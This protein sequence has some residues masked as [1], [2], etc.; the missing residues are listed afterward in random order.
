VELKVQGEQ[1]K[2]HRANEMLN[3]LQVGRKAPLIRGIESILPKFIDKAIAIVISR[4]APRI[5]QMPV[6]EL[7]KMKAELEKEKPVAIETGIRALERS[8]D[9]LSCDQ[10]GMTL[11]R[12]FDESGVSQFG[13]IWKTF[14]NFSRSLEN[15]FTRYGLKVGDSFNPMILHLQAVLIPNR[16][17][18]DAHANYC[19]AKYRC[20]SLED[21]LKEAKAREKFESA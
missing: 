18:G 14:Q 5:D 9:W 2:Y 19:R 17:V 6:D 16:A 13:P 21:A 12:A 4:N 10:H 11:R 20:D 8:P 3:L 15:V 7:R 1:R